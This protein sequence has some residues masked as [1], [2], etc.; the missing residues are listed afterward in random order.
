MK[1]RNSISLMVFMNKIGKKRFFVTGGA[2]FIGSNMV[3]RL[4]SEGAE[5]LV[6][7]NLSSGNIR[8]LKKFEDLKEFKFVKGDLLDKEF[9]YEKMKSDH[10]DAIIHFAANPFVIKG[11][12]ETD[13][14]MKQGTIVTYNVLESARKTDIKEIM[15]ASSGVVY[16]NAGIKPTPE[17]YG[18]LAPISLYGASK[19]ASE[20]LITAFSHLF[21]V[22][23]YIYRFPNVIGK[24]AT[25]G[26]IPDLARKIWDNKTE[27]EVLGNGKQSKSYVDVEDCVDGML[28]VYNNSKKQNNLY[29]LTTNNQISVNKIAEMIVE[30]FSP[31]CKVEYAKTEQG[32]PGDVTNVLLSGRKMKELGW[33]PKYN[34]FEAVR[35]SIDRVYSMLTQEGKI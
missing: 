21:G 6:Y 14:D 26:I 1:N 22:Y 25:H 3:E 4:I 32:W 31:N 24:N 11:I 19:L 34:S 30:R 17:D 13:L 23:Y 28:Y 12:R 33:E 10:F 35:H 5:V 8:F 15:F 7:D 9:L 20:G 27:L 29:N 2:G 18:P 16:G